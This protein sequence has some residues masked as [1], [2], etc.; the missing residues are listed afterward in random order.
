MEILLRIWEPYPMLKSARIDLFDKLPSAQWPSA[1]P[2]LQVINVPDAHPLY[3]QGDKCDSLFCIV[4]GHIMLSRVNENGDQV[5]I[6]VLKSGELFGPALSEFQITE[7]PET[8][9][10]KGIS[11]IYKIPVKEFKTFLSTVPDVAW[12]VIQMLS[13]RQKL[14]ERKL[15]GLL[16]KDV[17]ARLA[18]TLL[19]LAGHYGEKCHHGFEL[20]IKLT[21]QELA[22][23]VGASRPVISALLNGLKGR[24]ILVYTRDCIC[25]IQLEALKSLSFL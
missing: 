18:E 7:T 20:D 15:E 21:Q 2:L 25:I 9:I 11:L 6:A 14:L 1:C 10:A 22:D 23:L 5:A 24:G 17:Q 16:F 19:D 3:Y 4:Q 13:N 8:A 12:Q